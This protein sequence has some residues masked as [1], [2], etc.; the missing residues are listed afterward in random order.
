MKYDM[1]M[2]MTIDC[3][4]EEGNANFIIGIVRQYLR[5]T[6]QEDKLSEYTTKAMSGN[7]ANVLKT[8]KKYY[9]ELTFINEE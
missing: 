9:P 6:G 8:S 3:R 4:E 1:A 5:K 2:A 7:Y